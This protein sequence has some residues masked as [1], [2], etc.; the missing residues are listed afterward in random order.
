MNRPSQQSRALRWG[1]VREPPLQQVDCDHRADLIAL[2]A[3]AMLCGGNSQPSERSLAGTISGG[4]KNRFA[5]RLLISGA[6]TATTYTGRN[7]YRKVD[8][9]SA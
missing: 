5:L 3:L 7:S 4:L 8:V 6:P 2:I 1:A 9:T